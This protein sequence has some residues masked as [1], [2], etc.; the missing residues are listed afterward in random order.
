M[1][2]NSAPFSGAAEAAKPSTRH[3]L[4]KFALWL[5][6]ILL[7]VLVGFLLLRILLA[8]GGERIESLYALASSPWLLVF[9]ICIY[10]SLW[11]FWG[12][13]LTMFIPKCSPELM[14][15][16][17]RPLIVLLVCYELF[18]ASNVIGYLI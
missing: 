14:R 8:G 7:T 11:Y 1:N 17:R 2:H 5:I 6:G 10:V 15:A 12:K 4:K 18:F 13:F 9:R 16:T 3:K